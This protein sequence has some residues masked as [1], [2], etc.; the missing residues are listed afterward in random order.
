MIQ[1]DSDIRAL[2]GAVL[3]EAPEPP[4]AATILERVDQIVPMITGHARRGRA[5]RVLI[6]AS[7]AAGLIG[8]LVAITVNR[9]NNTTP[10]AAKTL[11]PSS[12]F[13]PLGTEV[14]LAVTADTAPTDTNGIVKSDSSVHVTIAGQFNVSWYTTV[15]MYEG[16]AVQMDCDFN[17]G[18]SPYLNTPGPHTGLVSDSGGKDFWSWVGVPAD[19]TYVVYTDGDTVQWQRPASGIAA[20]PAAS[21]HKASVIALDETGQTL[22]TADLQTGTPLDL[23]P[24]DWSRYRD[25]TTDQ[26]DQMHL[27]INDAMTSCLQ[28]PNGSWSG[29]VDH[30]DQVLV[31]WFNDRANERGAN[32]GTTP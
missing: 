14:Q 10:P 31:Q 23:P 1:R 19:A 22:A 12:T 9:G 21:G 15:A 4:T 5:A 17:G 24:F 8:G 30:A 6:T 11:A 20:F 16:H 18:C 29:C 32:N 27:V 26:Q 28:T 13:S 3:A 2:L 25:L 7:A